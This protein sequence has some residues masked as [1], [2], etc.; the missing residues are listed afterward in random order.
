MVE[1]HTSVYSG[2]NVGGATPDPIPNS[3]VKPSRADGTARVSEWESRT[4]PGL[5]PRFQTWKRGVSFCAASGSDVMEVR[6][7]AL[8][9]SVRGAIS[10]GSQVEGRAAGCALEDSRTNKVLDFGREESRKRIR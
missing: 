8:D 10:K 5:S 4:P 9:C 7:K 3:E 1:C 2:G 6:N